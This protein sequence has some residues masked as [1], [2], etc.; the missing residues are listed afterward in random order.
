MVFSF[1][2]KNGGGG[3]V[4]LEAAN[5]GCPSITTFETGLHDW[6]EGRWDIN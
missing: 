2:F 3:M 1:T 4:N 5:L 6:G